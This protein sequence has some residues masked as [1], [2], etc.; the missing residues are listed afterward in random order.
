MVAQHFEQIDAEYC[1]AEGGIVRRIGG[2]VRYALVQ[3]WKGGARDGTDRTQAGSVMRE[4]C[5][6]T[7]RR[8]YMFRR[9]KA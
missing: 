9:G 1:F 3:T 7:R 2:E 4:R 8:F 5:T 6:G